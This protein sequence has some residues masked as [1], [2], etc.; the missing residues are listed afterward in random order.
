[1]LKFA[2]LRVTSTN[3]RNSL[4]FCHLFVVKK[5][6]RVHQTSTDFDFIYPADFIQKP[7]SFDSHPRKKLA[8]FRFFRPFFRFEVGQLDPLH[9]FSPFHREGEVP[10]RAPFCIRRVASSLRSPPTH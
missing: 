2:R 8:K 5:F 9:P 4:A 10:P 6:A 7:N 3:P 1:M